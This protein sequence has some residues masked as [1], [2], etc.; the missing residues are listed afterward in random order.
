[1]RVTRNEYPSGD[2]EL[3][4][5]LA[6]DW[7]LFLGNVLPEVR[8][9]YLPNIGSGIVDYARKLDIDAILFTG[10][11]DWGVFPLRDQTEE[12]LFRWGE[13]RLIPMLGICRG[14]Q[15]INRLLGGNDSACRM[16]SAISHNIAV[17]Y[18]GDS[19]D[20]LKV[21]S[22]HGRCIPPNG[23]AAGLKAFAVAEDGTL[24][25]FYSKN[26][27]ICGIMWHP[28]R[29]GAPIDLDSRLFREFY[30]GKAKV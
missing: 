30:C 18:S 19:E 7:P 24:E 2:V 1:M 6:C 26:R 22:F 21:N 28:E 29:Q 27:R 13:A 23:L 12:C 16:H 4:D 3:R 10:G 17:R 15:V 25:G 5:A 9:A 8:F 14:A 20:I 11:D